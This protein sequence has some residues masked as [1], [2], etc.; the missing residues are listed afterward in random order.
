M[1]SAQ[2]V[3]VALGARGVAAALRERDATDLEIARNAAAREP[4]PVTW[5]SPPLAA[6]AA[7]AQQLDA[8]L[9]ALHARRAEVTARLERAFAEVA[10]EIPSFEVAGRVEAVIAVALRD[11]SL[12]TSPLPEGEVVPRELDAIAWRLIELFVPGTT[13]AQLAATALRDPAFAALCAA[14]RREAAEAKDAEAR[15]AAARDEVSS[16][17]LMVGRG[18]EK[19]QHADELARV[20]SREQ[21]EANKA[22]EEAWIAVLRPAEANPAVRLHTALLAAGAVLRGEGLD[23]V[24]VVNGPIPGVAVRR[25]GATRRVLFLAALAAVRSACD[26]AFPGVSAIAGGGPSVVRA[27]GA[28]ER[29]LG[30]YRGSGGEGAE[31]GCDRRGAALTA[32]L[33]GAGAGDAMSRALRHAVAA[34]VLERSEVGASILDQVLDRGMRGAAQAAADRVARAAWHRA[35]LASQVRMLVAGCARI[36]LPRTLLHEAAVLVGIAV[37][38]VSP[39]VAIGGLGHHDETLWLHGQPEAIAAVERLAFVSGAIL[40]VPPDAWQLAQDVAARL[41][42]GHAASGWVEALARQLHGTRFLATMD[43]LPG[44]ARAADE[45]VRAAGAA[46]RAVTWIDHLNV[47]STSDAEEAVERAGDAS[48][49]AESAMRAAW[50]EARG[51]FFAALEPHPALALHVAIADVRSAVAR[52]RAFRSTRDAPAIVLGREVVVAQLRAWTG[53][54]QRAHGLVPAVDVL[55]EYVRAKLDAREGF[56]SADRPGRHLAPGPPPL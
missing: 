22:F 51:L 3:L 9:A 45:A 11:P 34:G 7:S 17:A 50:D 20:L 42:S 52:L 27:L 4:A 16:L 15:L 13:L 54:A 40:G 49:A 32:L 6:S 14:A 18:H 38:R 2:A 1:S 37:S 48:A 39:A 46:T 25:P 55:E 31:V 29:G 5:D 10:A 35:I 36:E 43:A 19:A 41:R 12:G 28:A 44:L 23:D 26:A 30:P 33:D 21:L 8:E 53:G 24:F 47:F 56:A